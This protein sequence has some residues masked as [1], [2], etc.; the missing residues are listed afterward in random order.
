[1]L[2]E[3]L[4]AVDAFTA[5]VDADLATTADVS[6]NQVLVRRVALDPNLDPS[7]SHHTSLNQVVV[8]RG[9]SNLQTQPAP[10]AIHHTVPYPVVP[11][12]TLP[13]NCPVP[14]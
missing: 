10:S 8:T 11:C 3:L 5:R 4:G 13:E 6:F 2:M 12:E 9:A 1:M 14:V 7:A